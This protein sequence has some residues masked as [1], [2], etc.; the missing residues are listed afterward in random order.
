MYNQCFSANHFPSQYEEECPVNYS[1]KYSE[2]E[3]C[4]INAENSKT[5]FKEFSDYAETDLDQPTNFSWKYGEKP[6]EAIKSSKFIYFENEKPKYKEYADYAE[7]DLDQPTDFTLKYGELCEEVKSPNFTYFENKKLKA[8]DCCRNDS[9][10]DVEVLTEPSTDHFVSENETPLMFSRSSSLNSLSSFDQ[11]TGATPDDIGSVIS[12][13]SR[14][15]SG[16]ITPSDLPDSPIQTVP[17]SPNQ[18][19]PRKIFP[20]NENF[21]QKKS[22]FEDDVASYKQ[23]DTPIEF[24]RATSLSS[25]FIDNSLKSECCLNVRKMLNSHK[26]YFGCIFF[27][28]DLI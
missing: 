12:E 5:Q 7:T 18:N 1:L 17:P 10:R 26:M 6:E 24:S 21:Q 19:K 3:S 14:T 11:V 25:L 16:I 4:K 9:V 23:E 20:V 27:C 13:F 28:F 8:T 22:V 2:T 15:T